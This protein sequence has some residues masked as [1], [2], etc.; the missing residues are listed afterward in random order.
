[1][2]ILEDHVLSLQLKLNANQSLQNH[3]SSPASHVHVQ[4]CYSLSGVKCSPKLRTIPDVTTICC[5][6]TSPTLRHSPSVHAGFNH[7]ATSGAMYTPTVVHVHGFEVSCKSAPDG[8]G[9][10]AFLCKGLCPFLQWSNNVVDD[11]LLCLFI[12]CDCRL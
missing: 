5:N 1:M 3:N 10:H 6:R 7:L 9:G 11:W 8:T 12:R 2:Y 4:L